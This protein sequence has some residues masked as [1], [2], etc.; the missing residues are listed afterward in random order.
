VTRSGPGSVA[1]LL[2]RVVAV[3][4]LVAGV[5]V[6]DSWSQGGDLA[7]PP[8]ASAQGGTRAVVQPLSPPE[9]LAPAPPPVPGTGGYRFTTT[10]PYD[11]ERP[12]AFDPCRPVR[13]AVRPGGAVPGGEAL[14]DDAV[15]ELARVTGL[16]FE[17]VADTDEE[18][19]VERP[20]VQHD[21]YGPG[22]VPVLVAWSDERAW[23]PLT[24]LVAGV[25]GSQWMDVGRPDSRRYVTGMVVLDGE[26]LT[27]TLEEKNGLSR[28]RAVVLHELAHVVG[29]D[30]VP[31]P[32]ALMHP[33]NRDQAAF[34]EGDLRGLAALGSGECFTD[35]SLLVGTD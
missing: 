29:L 6:A 13:Y 11:A 30:H 21:R 14:V 10:Q 20:T 16:V 5:Q 33:H 3:V 2:R 4:V 26:Q 31:D 35:W 15:A 19:A 7:G 23:P 22:A 25:A 17:R 18:P 1:R 32:D 27:E 9:R 12:V 34:A 24:G 8:D 28:V